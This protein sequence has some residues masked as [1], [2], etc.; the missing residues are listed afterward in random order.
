[1]TEPFFPADV[2]LRVD[3][4]FEDAQSLFGIAKNMLFKAGSLRRQPGAPSTVALVHNTT[5]GSKVSVLLSRGIKIIYITPAVKVPPES[6]PWEPP[7][8]PEPPKIPPGP[9]LLNGWTRTPF[10]TTEIDGTRLFHDYHPTQ[11]NSDAYHLPYA[12]QTNVKLGT[13]FTSLT[14]AS[15]YSGTMKRVVQAILGLGMFVDVSPAYWTGKVITKKRSVD[16]MYSYSWSATHG[17]YKAGNKNHWIVEISQ[18]Q[19]I[20]AMPLPIFA[21]TKLA[22]YAAHLAAIGD[23]DTLHIVQEFGGLPTG[24]TFPDTTPKLEAAITRGEVLRL[25]SAADM[26]QFYGDGKEA[27]SLSFGWAFSESGSRANN[28]C[29]LWRNDTGSNQAGNPYVPPGKRVLWGEHWEVRI[30]LTQHNR[31]LTIQGLPVG[32]GSATVSLVHTGKMDPRSATNFYVPRPIDPLERIDY[33]YYSPAAV[34]SQARNAHRTLADNTGWG[35]DVFVFYEG[36]RLERLKWVPFE[37]IG[38]YA[39]VSLVVS[40]NPPLPSEPASD[41]DEVAGPFLMTQFE[42]SD[43]WSADAFVGTSLDLREL[44]YNGAPSAVGHE[45]LP[46]NNAQVDYYDGSGPDGGPYAHYKSLGPIDYSGLIDNYS[47]GEP[48][49]VAG[50]KGQT[51]IAMVPYLCREGYVLHSIIAEGDLVSR[52]PDRR[53]LTG[54]FAG[55]GSLRFTVPPVTPEIGS[56]PPVNGRF[57]QLYFSAVFNAGPSVQYKIDDGYKFSEDPPAVIW[58]EKGLPPGLQNTPCLETNWIGSV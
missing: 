29:W 12:F 18:N 9:Q 52:F 34:V 15:T 37:G 50:F 43:C 53:Q 8:Q 58:G 17:I 19:G 45:A 1:M 42:A 33:S 11:S 31:A 27:Y 54:Y 41:Y 39:I 49:G 4:S 35:A 30:A 21:D 13:P 2:S 48:V 23:T 51:I 14:R 28:T 10:I 36:E 5:D 22:T 38:S 44:S 20:L 55:V 7:V 24:E 57:G 25:A 16:V 56:Y 46:T 3:G 32:S 6:E 40:D 26:L 47:V